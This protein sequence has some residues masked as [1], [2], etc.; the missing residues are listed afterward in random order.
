MLGFR[1]WVLA[2]CPVAPAASGPPRRI[3]GRRPRRPG[4]WIWSPN[5]TGPSPRSR[6]TASPGSAPT[7]RPSSTWTPEPP[8]PPDYLRGYFH[9][10]T[11]ADYD[12][13]TVAA[14]VSGADPDIPERILAA[15]GTYQWAVTLRGNGP[16]SLITRNGADSAAAVRLAESKNWLGVSVHAA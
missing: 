6:S 4:S 8:A 11:L 14:W 12:L 10:V 13:R 7:W 16:L 1:A 3:R 9:V 2:K 15:A 5:G